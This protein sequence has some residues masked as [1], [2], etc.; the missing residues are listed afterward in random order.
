MGMGRRS[1]CHQPEWWVATAQRPQSPGH[2]FYDQLHALLAE[3]GCD[4]HVED[5]C[6]P[7]DAEGVGRDALPPGVYCRMLLV[8]YFEDL[9]SQR[10]IAWK[11]SASL[12]LC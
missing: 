9:D 1:E 10:G 5:L 8:G 11:C 12:L 6:Q 7:Y 2:V 4:R 3:A